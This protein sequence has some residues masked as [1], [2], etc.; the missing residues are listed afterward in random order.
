MSGIGMLDDAENSPLIN[1]LHDH[2]LPPIDKTKEFSTK[3][4]GKM[5][6]E[7]LKNINV[8]SQRDL[9]PKCKKLFHEAMKL[10]KKNER[11][12][13]NKN[14]FKTRVKLIE[15][16]VK[17]P[18]T[19]KLLNKLN[20]TTLEFFKSQIKCQTTK[21]KGRRY[22]LQDKLLSLSIFKNSPNGYRFLSTIFSLPSKKTLNNLLNRVPFEAGIN[23]HII[24]NLAHQASKLK[25]NNRLCSL[26]F[27][28][29]A[30]DPSL[31]YSQKNDLI[32]GF[33]F[34]EIINKI[35]NLVTMC[36]SFYYEE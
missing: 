23:D 12:R 28:E 26:V 13:Q 35:V 22:S 31:T 16:F 11:L 7:L 5:K 27:D 15:K 34:L 1:N 19:D 30:I 10:K 4:K 17:S 8:P 29:M 20:L 36:W 32:F 18:C 3:Y 2:I 6:N 14:N 9:T 24:K 33:E 25:P 21:P